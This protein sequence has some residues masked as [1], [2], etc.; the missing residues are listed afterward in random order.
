M[1]YTIAI[2]PDDYTASGKPPESDASSPRWSKLL[3][4]H[5]FH[6][7][8]VDVKHPDILEQLKDCYGFMWRWGHS[9]GMSRIAHR[10]LPVI[11]HDLGLLVYPDQNTCWH[12]DDKIAQAYLLGAKGIPIPR[13]WIWFDKNA[14]LDWALNADYPVVLKLAIG[15]GSNNVRLIRNKLEAQIWIERMFNRFVISLNENY[16]QQ[17]GFRQRIREAARILLK[18][19]LRPLNNSGLEPQSGYIIFQEFL[20]ENNHDTRVTVIGKRA[21]AFRRF[22]RD[23]DFR[24]SGSGKIDWDTKTIDKDFIRLAFKTAKLLRTQSCAIDGLYN[25]QTHV[26]GEVSYTYLS[27]AVFKCPGHWELEG[28]PTTG[29]LEWVEGQMWPEEAQIQDFL[30]KLK[31]RLAGDQ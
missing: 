5:G 18:G 30:V 20:P 7:K 11:E 15:A 10:L 8:W 3:E 9:G 21:F 25:S 16:Y 31:E 2:Q 23:N 12:Y 17:L 24:A 27:E 4:E 19:N 1:K 28:E 26:V 13:T 29:R 6:V 14:A 22:N